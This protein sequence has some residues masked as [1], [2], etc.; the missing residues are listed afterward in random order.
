MHGQKSVSYIASERSDETEPKWK[1]KDPLSDP[2]PDEVSSPTE[3]YIE[4]LVE[5]SLSK[6]FAQMKAKIADNLALV[7]FAGNHVEHP[8]ML[9]DML[10]ISESVLRDALESY[11][12]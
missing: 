10:V 11:C 5:G 7:V 3:E 12:A 2:L 1:E 9:E 6:D 8:Q 4:E